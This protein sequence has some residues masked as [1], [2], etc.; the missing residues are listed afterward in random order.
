[1]VMSTMKE[2]MKDV[3]DSAILSPSKELEDRMKRYME[4]MVEE[5][6]QEAAKKIKADLPPTF[7]NLGNKD[8]H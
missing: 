2:D 4:G 1:M 8:Q 5:T 7:K 3:F 6:F